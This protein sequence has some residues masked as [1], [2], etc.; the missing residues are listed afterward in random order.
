LLAE[1]AVILRGTPG[2][3]LRQLRRERNGF[4]AY[5]LHLGGVSTTSRQTAQGKK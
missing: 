4:A 2:N 5:S 1:I 3:V